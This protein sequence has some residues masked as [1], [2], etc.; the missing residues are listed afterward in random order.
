MR[1]IT[2]NCQG[3]FRKK[4]D[5]ILALQPDILVI[6]E[7]EHPDKYVYNLTNKKPDS[8]YWHGIKHKGICIQSFN[9][10]K[11]ELLPV[12]NSSFK[13]ILPFRVTGHGQTFILFAI[14]AKSDKENY[15]ARYIGQVWLAI[16]Y[17]SD[18]LKGST[19]LVGDFNSNKIWDY[20]TRVGDHSDVVDKLADSNIQ[21]I[22][23]RHF[24][25]EQGIEK[26]PTFFLQ[27]KLSKPYHIDYCFASG[28][29]LDKVQNV[30]IGTYEDW[31][32]YSD[33]APMTIDFDI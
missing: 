5:L 30:A 13:Y 21:S 2:W 10:Y 19:I 32:A 22:Y 11:F 17:Y 9:D 27:R 15:Y 20:K 28:D 31:S 1:L 6:Q 23:H 4:S 7:C 16:D 12:F 26:H 29:F 3:A 14:W 18:L 25:I 8:Q 33:H 24:E